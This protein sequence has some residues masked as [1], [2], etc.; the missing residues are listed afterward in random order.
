MAGDGAG[1]LKHFGPGGQKNHVD[2]YGSLAGYG[3]A[4]GFPDKTI[5]SGPGKIIHLVSYKMPGELIGFLGGFAGSCFVGAYDGY[6]G[7]ALEHSA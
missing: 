7:I 1:F 6:L 2:G 4:G 3:G 5:G